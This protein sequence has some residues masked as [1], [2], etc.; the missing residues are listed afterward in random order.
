MLCDTV[1]GLNVLDVP[2]WEYSWIE[3]R[4]L[5]GAPCR[6]LL[7][8]ECVLHGCSGRQL[9]RCRQPSQGLK[10]RMGAERF[11]PHVALQDNSSPLV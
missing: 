11:P 1:A 4:L 9:K 10:V 7:D 2:G 5:A 3:P 8:E 6:H